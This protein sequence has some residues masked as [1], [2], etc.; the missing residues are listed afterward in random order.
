MSE[1]GI[2]VLIFDLTRLIKRQIMN[3]TVLIIVNFL[4]SL[5]L[6]QNSFCQYE[7]YDIVKYT[8]PKDFKKI[9]KPE[10][11]I[12]S[13][14]DE[15]TGKFCL[16]ALYESTVSSGNVEKDFKDKWKQ[17]VL[18]RYGADQN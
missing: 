9:L 14:V 10:A 1:V 5:S 15:K 8:P 7:T 6:I 11:V 17:L 18:S 3:K 12:Y 16:I 13:I 4:F 2:D